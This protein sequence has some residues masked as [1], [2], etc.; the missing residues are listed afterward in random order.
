M[1]LLFADFSYE[2]VGAISLSLSL[3]DKDSGKI[4]LDIGFFRF[5]RFLSTWPKVSI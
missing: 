3:G 5:F 4:S 2:N 1:L